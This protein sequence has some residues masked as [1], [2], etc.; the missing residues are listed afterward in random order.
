MR[1]HVKEAVSPRIDDESPKEMM[2][3][4]SFSCDT[5]HG[6]GIEEVWDDVGD[7]YIDRN[8]SVC[9]GSGQVVGNDEETCDGC[10]SRL[11]EPHYSG[12]D[13]A[14]VT[15]AVEV[16]DVMVPVADNVDDVVACADGLPEDETTYDDVCPCCGEW[17]NGVRCDAC[18]KAE[19]ESCADLEAPIH[20]ECNDFDKFMD[21]TLIDE[22]RKVMV[23][24]EENNPQRRLAAR[25]QDR[26]L[27][28][29]R[30]GKRVL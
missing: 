4:M 6:T 5:C 15:E 23:S 7:E 19:F 12:C 16:I 26:P 27:N 3:E 13:F 22:G 21:R 18:D 25:Y 14:G 2:E 29:I 10:G 30:I 8:C 28:K 11:N 20:V 1:K 9:A 24:C 17:W